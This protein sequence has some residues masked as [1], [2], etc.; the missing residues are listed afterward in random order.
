MA[1]EFTE[2]I[3]SG[4]VIAPKHHPID[5]PIQW[6]LVLLGKQMQDGG[7]LRQK[8]MFH[9]YIVPPECSNNLTNRRIPNNHQ[10]MCNDMLYEN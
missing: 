10:I 9:K 4:I 2:E 5:E 1:I 8:T 7:H 6:L 3:C